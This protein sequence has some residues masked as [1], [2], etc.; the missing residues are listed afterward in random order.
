MIY[1]VV[2]VSD[3]QQSDSVTYIWCVCMCVYIYICIIF[4]FFSITVYKILNTVSSLCY[5]VE[6]CCLSILH[7]CSASSLTVQLFTTP[8]TIAHQAPLF[9]G[10][11]Q[12]RILKW[13]AIPSSRGS[14]QPRDRTHVSHIT[15]GFFTVWI[16]RED[17]FVYSSLYLLI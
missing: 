16:T 4:R 17:H 3:A 2:L 13:V 9:V 11:L 12:A 10:I 6:L 1:N 7:M 14:S 8:W 5:A 15:G